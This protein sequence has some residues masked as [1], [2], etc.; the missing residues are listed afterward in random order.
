MLGVSPG[1]PADKA[2][3]VAGDVIVALDGQRLDDGSS[4]PGPR[5]VR[6]MDEVEPGAIV[7]VAYLR[8]GVER[9][10][11]VETVPFEQRAFIGEHLP[12]LADG[13]WLDGELPLPPPFAGVWDHH[14]WRGLELV[15]VGP[16]L[17][18]YFGTDEG[19][20]V[21]RMRDDEELPFEPG[22]VI[23]RIGGATPDNV[24]DA[25]R[26]LRFYK[27]GDTIVFEIMREQRGRRLEV[28]VP[29]RDG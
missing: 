4:P 28:V 6:I 3:I 8:D 15:P 23:L 10:V 14:G 13:A 26:L 11:D 21:V 24:P 29:A 2:G 9:T 16:D 27:P 20:L 18:R 12:P 17:G 7:R 5:L 25:M 1:G 22:D 19:L